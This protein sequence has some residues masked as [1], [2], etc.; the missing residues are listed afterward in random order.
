MLFHFVCVLA[1]KCNTDPVILELMANLGIG[2]DCASKVMYV[3]MYLTEY[4]YFLYIEMPIIHGSVFLA[5]I[6]I[7]LHDRLGQAWTVIK[8]QFYYH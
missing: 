2:F 8:K 6:F 3:C 1:I 5:L 7:L 4:Q